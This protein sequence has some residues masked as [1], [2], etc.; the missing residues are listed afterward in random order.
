MSG[1]RDGE[2]PDIDECCDRVLVLV[3]GR[4]LAIEGVA[5]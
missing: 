5:P 1:L 3:R 2:L 4:I